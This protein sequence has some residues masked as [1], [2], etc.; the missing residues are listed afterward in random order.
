M[1]QRW[2]SIAINCK[3]RFSTPQC[4]TLAVPTG[5]QLLLNRLRPLLHGETVALRIT[6][7][8]QRKKKRIGEPVLLLVPGHKLGNINGLAIALQGAGCELVELDSLK[9]VQFVRIGLSAPASRKL[10]EALQILYMES[11]DS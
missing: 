4:K 10:V 7:S 8:R 2:H 5:G 3:D 1:K 6:D 11:C 9:T